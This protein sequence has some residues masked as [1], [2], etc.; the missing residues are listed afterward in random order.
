MSQMVSLPSSRE[1][2]AVAL[3]DRI[4]DGEYPPG[5]KLPSERIVALSSGLSRPIVREVLR[6]LQERGLIDIQAGR[7]AYVRLPGSMNLAQSMDLF[8]RTEGT[9]PRD[10]VEARAML[11][12]QTA[13]LAASRATDDEIDALRDLS[14]AFDQANNVID[15]ARCDLAFHAMIAKGSHNPVLQT[16][17]AAIAPLVFELQLRSLDD[18]RILDA[19]APLHHV[20]LEGISDH[21][22]A[23]AGA[24]IWKHVTL[25]YEMFGSDL[26][27]SLNAIARRKVSALLGE[28]TTLEAV[29][30]DVLSNG[31]GHPL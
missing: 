12:D 19:G 10:L 16:M 26:E 14:L 24:A 4:L 7:G 2:L 11:E 17:F 1:A 8:A 18:P 5:S 13:R 21:D 22:E 27:L 20:V 28:H 15:R 25:A 30:A 29:I 31:S 3:S 23:I 9:T 6:G